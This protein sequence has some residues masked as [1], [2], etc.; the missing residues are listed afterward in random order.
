[1]LVSGCSLTSNNSSSTTKV[2]KLKNINN[3]LVKT[4][5]ANGK[6][7]LLHFWSTWCPMCKH[8]LIALQNLER[9]VDRKKIQFISVA[10]DSPISDVIELIQNYNL[11][12]KI[13]IDDED[14]AKDFYR[15]GEIPQS[16]LIDRS[17]KL[18]KILE[19][20]TGK[21]V[22]RTKG[23]QEWDRSEAIRKFFKELK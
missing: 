17:G 10:I 14:V 7:T 19:P 12:L 21:M 1:M 3:Q 4:E 15:I 2:L 9:T 18:I 13:V 11:K 22:S 20:E 16:I 6:Y 23:P 5:L 8:E